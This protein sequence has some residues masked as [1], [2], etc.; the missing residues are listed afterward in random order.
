MCL[1]PN[2]AATTFKFVLIPN[3]YYFSTLQYR[4]DKLVRYA[5]CAGQLY[6]H[7]LCTFLYLT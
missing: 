2:S 6:T 5:R 3:I 1:L 4:T 7:G